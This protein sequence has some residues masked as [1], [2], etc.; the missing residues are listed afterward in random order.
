M[1]S[2][3][4]RLPG[5]RNEGV[6]FA[7]AP[8]W[9]SGTGI[10]SPDFWGAYACA[11]CHDE[12]DGRRPSRLTRTEKEAVWFRAVFETQY[13]LFNDDLLVMT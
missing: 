7:H 2:C 3:S 11:R 5:C 6:V 13:A 1:R 12:L 9:A 10:K 4:V 8:S